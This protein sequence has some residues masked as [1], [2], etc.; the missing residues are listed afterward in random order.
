MPVAP[1]T[2]LYVPTSLLLPI[3]IVRINRRDRCI[4]ASWCCRAAD[5]SS[6]PSAEMLPMFLAKVDLLIVTFVTFPRASFLWLSSLS[7]VK[8]VA[9]PLMVATRLPD[10]LYLIGCHHGRIS[11]R[12]T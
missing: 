1:M 3:T 10:R 5:H 7:T 11:N 2:G 4:A 6:P 8:P 9:S 12:L